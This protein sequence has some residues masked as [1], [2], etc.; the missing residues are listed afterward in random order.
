ME[1]KRKRAQKDVSFKDNY[2]NCLQVTQLEKK[3]NYL[4]KKKLTQIVL[5]K[6]KEFIRN[7]KLI[8]KT[9]QKIKS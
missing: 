7:N 5:K 9:Q 1:I 4:E 8:L 3:I 2:K 6:I